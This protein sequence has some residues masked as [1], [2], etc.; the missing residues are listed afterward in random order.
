M[1]NFE[2]EIEEIERKKEKMGKIKRSSSNGI[3]LKSKNRN[4]CC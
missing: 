2:K 4:N 1:S 3:G